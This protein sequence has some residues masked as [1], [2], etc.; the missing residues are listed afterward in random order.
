M[1]KIRL[2]RIL[3]IDSPDEFRYY[4]NLSSLLEE[5]SFIEENLIKDLLRDIDK[6]TLSDHMESFFEAFLEHI[7]DNENELY[8]TV[9]SVKRAFDGMIFDGMSDEDISA[10]SS[11]IAKFRKWYVHDLN[12]FNRLSG[13][14]TS[15]RDARYDIVAA[16]L[17][18]DDSDYDFRTALDYDLDGFDVR[19]ADILASSQAGEG[20]GNK[21]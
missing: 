7:P 18:G 21:A 12:A 4:E 2:Y 14:E 3:D 17:L 5:D 13:E 20:T 9:E 10:L 1:D 8:I 15:I 19:V 16:R 6:D 11:E